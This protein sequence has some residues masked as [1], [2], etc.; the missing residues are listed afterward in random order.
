MFSKNTLLF[1][2]TAF[3]AAC[4]PTVPKELVDAREAYARA[5]SGP[6][7]SVV[8]ADLHKAEESLGVAE[9]AFKTY[10]EAQETRDAAYIAERRAEL[11]EALAAQELNRRQKAKADQDY[12]EKLAR[13]QTATKGQLIQTREQLAETQ[14]RAIEAQSKIGEAEQRA[15]EAERKAAEAEIRLHS[16]QEQLA[17]LAAVKEEP[18]GMVI[19]LNGSVLFPSDQA[20]LLPEA[21][22]R[23]DQVAAALMST[24]ERNIVVEG[25]TDSRGSDAHNLDLSQRRAEAV[26]NYIVNR[27]YEP[28][29]IRARGMGK[30]APVAPNSSA[31]GRAN[32]RRVEIIIEPVR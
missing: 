24:K 12:Q 30:A 26:R 29:R 7:A 4:A 15:G 27:G 23:L 25:Y 28:D 31:E 32:N 16:M 14:R 17:K 5:A 9:R 21:N 2:C 22:V 11:A 6:A 13:M 10:P 20:T 8:P 3:A 1:V 18:R 19:T